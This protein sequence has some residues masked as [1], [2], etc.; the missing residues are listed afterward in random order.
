MKQHNNKKH[1]IELIDLSNKRKKYTSIINDQPIGEDYLNYTDYAK[2]FGSLILDDKI[3]LPIT[4]GIYA[5]WGA[6][7]SFLLGKI[8]EYIQTNVNSKL[9]QTVYN[10]HTPD[11]QA[12][13]EYIIIDFNAWSYSFSDVLWAGL[14]KEIHS[15]VE[16]R[17]GFISLRLF[18][19]FCYP[20]RSNSRQKITCQIL[21]TIIRFIFLVVFSIIIGLISYEQ[22]LLELFGEIVI[23]SIFGITIATILPSIINLIITMCKDRGTD[24]MKGA[25]NIEENVGFMGNV[26]DELDLICDYV[27]MKKAKFAV[28]IDDLDRCSPDKI[29]AMLDATMLLLSNLNYPF[30]TFIAIDP[31]FIVKSIEIFYSN[32]FKTNC[33]TGF[34]YLDKLIQIPFNI[35]IASPKTK[36]SIVSILTR[37]KEDTL[38]IVFDLYVY[39][40]SKYVLNMDIK[41]ENKLVHSISNT[42]LCKLTY[43]DKIKIVQQ[44]YDH[45]KKTYGNILDSKYI[46][47]ITDTPYI[48]QFLLDIF[49]H[50]KHE[51]LNRITEYETS[52]LKNTMKRLRTLDNSDTSISRS[53]SFRIRSVNKHIISNMDIQQIL[54]DFLSAGLDEVVVK[55][56]SYPSSDLPTDM[57]SLYNMIRKGSATDQIFYDF[58]KY[59]E[60]RKNSEHQYVIIEGLN[61]RI[62]AYYEYL[63]MFMNTKMIKYSPINEQI[64]NLF[65]NMRKIVNTI[66]FSNKTLYAHSQSMLSSAEVAYFHNIS[67]FFDGNCRR[68]KKIINI[69][70]IIKNM[71]SERITGWYT[72][73][74]ITTYTLKII[75][76]LVVLF[77]QWPY[78]MSCIFQMIENYKDRLK[79]LPCTIPTTISDELVNTIDIPN[80]RNDEITTIEQWVKIHRLNTLHSV[81]QNLPSE[82]FDNDTLKY[83]IC[84]DYN[85]ILFKQFLTEQQPIITIEYF[86]VCIGYIFNINYTIKDQVEKIS[87]YTKLFK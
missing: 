47:K 59:L 15:K 12:Y 64:S 29:V 31:R 10:G 50:L 51:Y 66:H 84:I 27:Q 76:K 61:E 18:R 58:G 6:G 24:I 33:I 70:V 67:H 13:N 65:V 4:I 39:L 85:T 38:N 2:S 54:S 55:E 72:S 7:K 22:L 32:K 16:D 40:S 28:F 79:I 80:D 9:T 62:C 53:S 17:Y 37:E 44:I 73:K 1:D 63:R 52:A 48:L 71:L 78:R 81:F 41:F 23:Y 42:K 83:M 74:P 35:P 25:K 36:D 60:K 57:Q 43:P 86:Y 19:F 11:T 69:Y 3:S 8:K 49:T 30:L 14:V 5:R 75:I 77:E 56:D 45:F 26:R 87:N 82:L 46:Y 34:E 68:N 20:F 21:Y